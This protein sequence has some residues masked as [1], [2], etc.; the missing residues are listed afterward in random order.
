M[1]TSNP[2]EI[3]IDFGITTYQTLSDAIK[4]LIEASYDIYSKLLSKNKKITI[5]CGGQSPA[6]YCLA[7]M[8]LKIFNPENVNIV[9]L[10]HSKGGQPSMDQLSE[11]K[12]Y[13]ERLKEKGIKLHNDVVII[14]G[15]HSG[16]GILALESSL[17]Y[18]FKNINV[19]KIALNSQEGIAKIYVNEEIIL[20]SEPKFSDTFPRI[21]TSY[22]PINFKDKSKFIT[23]FINLETNPI[24]EIIIDLARIYPEQKVENSQW[25]KLNNIITEEIARKKEINFQEE[26]LIKEKKIAEIKFKAQEFEKKIKFK[27]QEFEKND[28]FKPIVLNNPKRYQCPLCKTITGTYAPLNPTDVSLFAHNFNCDNKFK[29]PKEK[30]LYYCIN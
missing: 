14:D 19:Y 5:V 12:N 13:C 15:V 6:Y 27:A 29:I 28:F 1:Y 22:Y 26:K 21:V 7:M 9:I 4:E 17:K 24:A 11:N 23:T 30:N 10:P 3:S 8:H 18:C 16:T 20:P 25:Y 2:R